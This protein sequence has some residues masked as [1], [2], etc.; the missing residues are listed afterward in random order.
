M[1]TLALLFFVFSSRVGLDLP[2]IGPPADHL[3]VAHWALDGSIESDVGG[4]A[5]SIEPTT[6]GTFVPIE[7]LGRKG[8]ALAPGATLKVP[9][10]FD[11]RGPGYLGRWA[12]VMDVRVAAPTKTTKHG[13]RALWSEVPLVQTDPANLDSAEMALSSTRGLEVASAT[14]GSITPDGWHRVAMVVDEHDNTVTGFIDGVMTRQVK[15]TVTDSRWALEPE[16]LLFADKDRSHPGLELAGLQVHLGKVSHTLIEELGG[17]TRPLPRH[18]TTTLNW[19]RPPPT[20]VAAGSPFLVGF[21]A[22]PPAGEVVLSFQPES[23]TALTLAR[24][25]ADSG[26]LLAVLP[27]LDLAETSGKLELV[28]QGAHRQSVSAPLTVRRGAA[29]PHHGDELLA[30][31]ELDGASQVEGWKVTG[32]VTAGRGSVAGTD[33]DFTLS[34]AVPIASGLATGGFGFTAQVRMRRGERAS[35]LGDRGVLSVR[36]RNAAGEVLATHESLGADSERLHDREI[37][38]PIPAGSIEAE[39]TFKAFE[40]HGDKNSVVVERMGL[41]TRSLDGRPLRLSKNP[42]V[43]GRSGSSLAIIF[44]TDGADLAPVVEVANAAGDWVAEPIGTTTTVDHRHVVHLANLPERPEGATLRYRVRLGEETSPTWEV[45]VPVTTG[46][47]RMGFIADNQHGWQTFRTL[48]PLLDKAD[49]DL[50]FVAGDFVQHGYKLREWQTEW[51]SPLSIDDFGQTIPLM[52]ARGNHDANGAFA[53][54]YA[55]LPGNGHWYAF[56][57]NGVRFIVLDT[58]SDTARTPAQLRWLEDELASDASRYAEFRVV[59]FHRPPFSNR[60]HS[61]S[62]TYDGETW[63]RQFIVPVLTRHKVD[64]VV[65]GHAH[66]YQRREVDGVHYVVVGGAGGA[67]DRYKTGRWPMQVDYV[68]HHYAVMESFDRRLS[69]VVRDF[70]GQLVDSFELSSRTRHL[71]R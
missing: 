4:R 44:E 60:W 36:F 13:K 57:R 49:I 54:A 8:L 6:A 67:L 69:W 52:M 21:F 9:L 27:D 37:L 58:E 7:T 30:N 41:V 5:I 47:L 50:L 19:R 61:K 17:P 14:A 63:V 38:G 70:S 48:V 39:V 62:S 29:A 1:W 68:G 31:P 10:A 34:Q 22:N 55:P 20:T 46:R 59:T 24:G 43:L 28:W 25:P 40:R 65:A 16:L 35:S 51:F 18:D 3:S 71:G 53:H 11:L 56:S 66:A 45:R 2:Q 26:R 15:T 64:L 32:K 42:L 12:L 23:G 33:G